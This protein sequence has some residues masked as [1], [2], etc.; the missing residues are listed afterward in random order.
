[1]R[2]NQLVVR[3]YVARGLWLWLGLRV[4]ISFVFLFGGTTP[5]RLATSTVVAIVVVSALLGLLETARR[6]ERALL[7]NLGVT[8]LSLGA[9]LVVP[10][11]MGE[12]V[13]QAARVVLP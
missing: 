8:R 5:L 10:P 7:G 12:L 6:S 13:L 9:L 4:S 2:P 11:T 3:A 1:M